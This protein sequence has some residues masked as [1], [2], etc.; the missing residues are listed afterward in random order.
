MNLPTLPSQGA[1]LLPGA[2]DKLSLQNAEEAFRR[3]IVPAVAGAAHAADHAVFVQ[4]PLKAL[5]GILCAPV[6]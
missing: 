5:S 1:A 6:G 3:G 4:L 2:E